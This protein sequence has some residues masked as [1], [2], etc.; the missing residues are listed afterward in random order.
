MRK[1]TGTLVTTCALSATLLVAGCGDGDGD[2]D[3]NA[4][5]AGEVLLQP[6]EAQGPDPFTDSTATP[7]TSPL[8]VTRTTQPD[9]SGETG[10]RSCA[11]PTPTVTV[12]PGATREPTDAPTV[13]AADC[14]TE[15]VTATPPTSE[16]ESPQ[17]PSDAPVTPGF[18]T[19]LPD[20]P[21]TEDSGDSLDSF[22]AMDEIGPETVPEIPDLPD[23]G[24]LI[25]DDPYSDFGSPTDLIDS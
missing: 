5:A 14:P 20:E 24:G 11:T 1:P 17:V 18:R 3:R 8:P 25:P 22:D 2:K 10:P 13:E 16:P 21:I 12:T 4:M 9:R 7:T 19:T 23:G 15:T 6:V